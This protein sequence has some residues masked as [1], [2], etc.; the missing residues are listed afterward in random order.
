MPVESHED[1]FWRSPKKGLH[2]KIFAQK[3]AKF[4]G[5]FEE[6]GA[7]ILR[8]PKNLP[9][10]TPTV[11]PLPGPCHGVAFSGHF[12]LTMMLQFE[13]LFRCTGYF[14]SSHEGC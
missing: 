10:P 12:L 11:I 2:E 13:E 14:V 4:F 1:L 7:K 8:T 9:T 3:M 6:I 5:K